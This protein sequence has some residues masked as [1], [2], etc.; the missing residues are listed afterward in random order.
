MVVL[1]KGV[2]KPCLM[3]T[4]RSMLK[5]LATGIVLPLGLHQCKSMSFRIC[6]ASCRTAS[7]HCRS[8]YTSFQSRWDEPGCISPSS[9]LLRSS[10][11]VLACSSSSPCNREV[12]ESMAISRKHFT[13]PR[14]GPQ[15]SHVQLSIV[16]AQA[17]LGKSLVKLQGC[18]QLR[19]KV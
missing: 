12:I 16:D 19:L 5:T 17:A 6:I 8:R 11:L 7:S 15:K 9:K 1:T 14:L 13:V 2:G 10:R 4:K 3:V 18:P